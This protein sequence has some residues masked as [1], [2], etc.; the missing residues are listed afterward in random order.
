MKDRHFR[1]IDLDKKTQ[2]DITITCPQKI[3]ESV[4]KDEVYWAFEDMEKLG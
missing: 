3:Q 4:F 2:V 1:L